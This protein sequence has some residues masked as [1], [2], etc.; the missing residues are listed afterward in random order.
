M[1]IAYKK[2]YHKKIESSGFMDNFP[3]NFLQQMLIDISVSVINFLL[4]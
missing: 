2:K 3:E 4:L 1:Y